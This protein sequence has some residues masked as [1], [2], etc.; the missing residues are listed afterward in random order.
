MVNKIMR[1]GYVSMV[2]KLLSILIVAF[3][4]SLNAN[5]ANQKYVPGEI[6]VKFKDGVS[7]FKKMGL[8]NSALHRGQSLRKASLVNTISQLSIERWALPEG[9]SVEMAMSELKKNENILYAEPNYY[10]HK[11]ALPDDRYYGDQWGLDAIDWLDVWERNP[12]PDSSG[13]TVAVVDDGVFA[14]HPDLDDRLV[15]GWNVLSGDGNTS[16]NFDTSPEATHGTQVAGIIGAEINNNEGIAGTAPNVRIMPILFTTDSRRTTADAADAF[17]E[18]IRINADIVNFSYG[19]YFYSNLLADA[20]KALEDEGIL[21]VTSAGNDEVNNRYVPIYPGSLPNKN[22]ITVSSVSETGNMTEWAQYGAF[23]VD[24]LAPGDNII[25]TS[26][27]VTKVSDTENSAT[28]N[29][30]YVSGTSFSAP[31]VAGVAALIKGEYALADMYEIKGRIMAGVETHATALD[32]VAAGGIANAANSLSVIPAP[33]LVIKSADVDSSGNGIIDSGETAELVIELENIWSDATTVEATLVPLDSKI[34]IEDPTKSFGNIAKGG[35]ASATYSISLDSFSGHRHIPFQL[36]ISYS[37][38]DLAPRFF[39]LES[40]RLVNEV[41]LN[42]SFDN[43]GYDDMHYYYF[44]VPVGTESFSIT[45]T[46][47]KDIDLF[48][49]RGARPLLYPTMNKHLGGEGYEYIY[50]YEDDDD[51]EKIGF[52][53]SVSSSGNEL[54]SLPNPV[55]G[56]YF[57]AVYN[58]GQSTGT[59]YTISAQGIS[60]GSTTFGGGGG[61]NINMLLLL[62][63]FGFGTALR[64]RKY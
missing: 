58:Y 60:S 1:N 38:I 39:S 46:S 41:Q 23:S 9:E 52:S 28:A 59:S 31:Y 51:L 12:Q 56:D 2:K 53:R 25:T 15:P 10:L 40:G 34:S 57:V 20:V 24:L 3:M 37:G 18:A 54:I 35:T 48:V 64:I 5:A 7:D 6:L 13:V 43:S 44:N 27:N 36:D 62:T 55:S 26:V 61:G 17:Y 8:R 45:A 42:A 30:T 47:L 22:I 16:P 63:L 14:S 21:L 4:F 19:A 49:M 33:V 32:K 11:M 50:D 29:Y